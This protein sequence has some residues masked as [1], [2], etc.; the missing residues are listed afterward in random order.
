MFALVVW[1]L[2]VPATDSSSLRPS[3]EAFNWTVRDGGLRGS[4]AAKLWGAIAQNNHGAI[5]CRPKRA[6][7]SRFGEFPTEEASA[8][9][10]NVVGRRPGRAQ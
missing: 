7:Q 5:L 10:Q 4:P 6:S 9:C 3:T 2:M 1:Y 8:L